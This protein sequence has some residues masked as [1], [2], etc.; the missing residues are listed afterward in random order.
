M[1]GDS[2][3]GADKKG[4]TA[5]CPIVAYEEQNNEEKDKVSF[6]ASM[7]VA[8]VSEARVDRTVVESL[9]L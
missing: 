9:R 1:D 3:R 5:G 4:Q 7:L 8:I 2:K 6:V